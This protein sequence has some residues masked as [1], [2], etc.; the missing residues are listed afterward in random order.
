MQNKHKGYITVEA[1]LVVPLFLFFMLALSGISMLLMAEAHIHQSLAEAAGSVAQ[2]SYLENRVLSEE[3]TGIKKVVDVA[4]LSKQFR[5]YLGED[6]YVE[7]MVLNGK[8]G[9]VLTSKEDR[10]NS[11][12]F[13]VKA[14]YLAKIKLPILGEFHVKVINE[15]KQKAFLGFSKDE[16]PET[17][18]YVTPNQSVYHKKRGCTHLILSVQKRNSSDRG[19]YKPCKLC[20]K[21]NNNLG[22][23]YIAKTGNV[24]H[25]RKECSGLKRTVKRVRLSEVSGL[26]ACSRCGE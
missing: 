10:L 11:K 18:V 1:C 20:A 8:N 26:S 4:L 24:Y 23:I 16:K 13:T 6:F 5:T 7:K 17:Y 12:I 14:S 2:Y 25:Y 9:I 3:N 22:M 19:H 21:E 15:V